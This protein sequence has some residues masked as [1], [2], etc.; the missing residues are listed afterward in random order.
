MPVVKNLTVRFH[1][2]P[3]LDTRA[4][5]DATNRR[6]AAL[7][8][9]VLPLEYDV[10]PP[11]EPEGVVDEMN[12]LGVKL[13]TWQNARSTAKSDRAREMLASRQ[14]G[15]PV[16]AAQP[17]PKGVLQQVLGAA[18]G[19]ILGGGP[20]AQRKA[21]RRGRLEAVV[22]S[23]AVGGRRLDK[24]VAVADRKE[25]SATSGMVWVVVINAEQ[26][27]APILLDSGCSRWW[28]T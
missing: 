17:P 26:G 15:G 1:P 9:R 2:A 27:E 11:T 24:K 8:G 5:P 3:A 18:S 10:L 23:T 7:E 28:L 19:G 22:G 16:A 25:A 21:A 4:E 13:N 14:A 12:A 6:I 20:L